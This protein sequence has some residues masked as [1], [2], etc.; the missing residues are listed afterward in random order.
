MRV[1]SAAEIDGALSFATL[2]EALERAFRGDV[3]VPH[4][5]HHEIARPG[6]PATLLLMP[7]WTG[8]AS[9]AHVGVKVVSVYPENA[10]RSL[11]SVFGTYLLMDGATGEPLAALDGTRLTVWRTA[12]ASALAARSLA[13]EDATR[14]VMIGA[15]ALAPF[16]IR[17]HA[18]VRPIRQVRI[19]NHRAEKARTLA[20]EL[21][22]E[23]LPAEAVE[24]LEPAVRE[25]DVV[26]C[27]TLSTAPLVRGAWLKAGAH[28]DLVG[29][30]NLKMREAD[31]EALA[32]ASVYIDTDAARSE[33]GDVA[34]GLRSG[35]I[36]SE[37]IRGDLFD[38]CRGRVAGRTALGE[39]TLFKS[40]GSAIEDLA[41]AMAVWRALG[42]R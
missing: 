23:G 40:V 39:I 30:F 3:V 31:D 13:R 5:H 34:V 33:G 32:R 22:R 26:S 27:A 29:A 28:L 4:R 10:A 38:L 18:G 16:L 19:W 41:A 24:E 1:V 17:A 7:A 11:P 36:A 14:M 20:A 21:S 42:E 15:G 9:E 37:H 2:I 12:A 25:A 35:A 6:S 8:A